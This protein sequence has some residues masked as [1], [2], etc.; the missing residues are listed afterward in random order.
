[1]KKVSMNSA[2]LK[3]AKEDADLIFEMKLAIGE[4]LG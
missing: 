1:M 3:M 2:F 4:L